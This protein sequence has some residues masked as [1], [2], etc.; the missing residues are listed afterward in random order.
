MT[1]QELSAVQRYGMVSAVY[2]G[3]NP[4]QPG[5]NFGMTS[6]AL[7]GQA[8]PSRRALFLV[9]CMSYNSSGFTDCK[10]V[11]LL[12]VLMWLTASDNDH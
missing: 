9:P 4:T 10:A 7:Q 1:R 5:G 12:S 11:L 6:V 3:S 2:C 8:H